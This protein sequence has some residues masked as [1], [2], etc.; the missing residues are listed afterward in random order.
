MVVWPA[1][2][3]GSAYHPRAPVRKTSSSSRMVL[4]ALSRSI[5]VWMVSISLRSTDRPARLMASTGSAYSRSR[6]VL[7]VLARFCTCSSPLVIVSLFLNLVVLFLSTF[8]DRRLCHAR[9]GQEGPTPPLSD[10][11]SYTCWGAGSPAAEAR[12]NRYSLHRNTNGQRAAVRCRTS[13][14][15]FCRIAPGSR[16]RTIVCPNYTLFLG[17]QQMTRVERVSY[18]R[19]SDAFGDEPLAHS[20]RR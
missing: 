17:G 5:S 3:L 12:L 16:R 18:G 10:W 14:A 8:R 15:T 2:T 4:S 11:N 6:N 19:E 1:L 7:S 13:P 9:F 20:W